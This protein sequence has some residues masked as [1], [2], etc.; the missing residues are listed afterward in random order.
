MKKLVLTVMAVVSMA[1]ISS[2]SNM[3]SSYNAYGGGDKCYENVSP[4]TKQYI[5]LKK[6]LD[7]CEQ[8]FKSGKSCD[9]MLVMDLTYLSRLGEF[10]VEVYP[11]NDQ[12]TKEEEAE[13]N[14]Q[15]EQIKALV[16]GI[17]KQLNCDFGVED[18]LDYLIEDGELFYNGV[19]MIVEEMPQFPGDL[20][21][22]KDYL[23]E[24]INYPKEA[25]MKGVQGRVLVSFVVERDGSISNVKA[26]Q[27]IG[28]GCDEEAVRVIES[29]PKW[30]PGKQSGKLVRVSCVLPVVF[31]LTDNTEK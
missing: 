20:Q 7:E 29:M 30:K 12:C 24:N 8:E 13:L 27:G 21:D 23:A 9:D 5:D 25:R 19:Q 31:E 11:E 26:M 18:M 4:H 22:L 16:I 17:H 15:L 6:I 1:L 2:A 14:A 10:T 28:S 3:V